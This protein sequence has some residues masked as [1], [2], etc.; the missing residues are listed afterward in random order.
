M[1][2]SMRALVVGGM[3]AVAL[4]CAAAFP[5][6]ATEAPAAAPVTVA[7]GCYIHNVSGGTLNI[8]SG[9]GTRYTGIGTMA[10]GSRLPCG[11]DKESVTKGQSYTSCGGG[12]G[13]MT[14]KIDGRDGWVA[15]ECVA[16]GAN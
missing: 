13:W 6:N 2:F 1:R 10:A 9:P 12:N 11:V 4:S 5:V 8:R 16:V 7:T 3:S 14:V 15:E